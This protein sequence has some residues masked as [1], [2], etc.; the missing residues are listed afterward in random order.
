MKNPNKTEI[1]NIQTRVKIIAEI[2]TSHNGSIER[3]EKLVSAAAVSGADILKTQIVFADEIIH[4]KTGFV[5]LP[6]GKIPLYDRFRQLETGFD[7]YRKLK[8][9]TE[10]AG[11]EFLAS[12]FGF[13]SLDWLQQ[14]GCTSIKIASPELNH[15]PL[16][17]RAASTGKEIILST[18]VSTP[19]DIKAALSAV[20]DAAPSEAA[21]PVLLHCITAYPAPEEEYNLL[22]LKTLKQEYGTETGVSDHSLDAELVP[23]IAAALNAR[24]IEKHITL[25]NN[26]GGLDDPI[27]LTPKQFSRM[28]AAVRETEKLAENEKLAAAR[29]RFGS[30]RVDVILGNGVKRLAPSEAANYGRTNRSVHALTDLASGTVLS[31]ENTALLRTEKVLR[32]GMRPELY[33]KII[34]KHLTRPVESGQ[35]ILIE[36]VEISIPDK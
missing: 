33:E 7:F 15:F 8:E 5:E 12:P 3:A 30:A 36:D 9:L 25:Q 32:P 13:K 4:P 24:Y 17:H 26:D 21:S 35:G 6:G 20:R 18:G 11:L 34:G 31:Q 29:E 28:S 14:L 19:A 10:E 23:V 22:L 27:A 16:L 2:G 1:N